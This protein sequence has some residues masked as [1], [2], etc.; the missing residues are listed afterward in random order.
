MIIWLIGLSGSGK[1]TLGRALHQKLKARHPNLIFVDGD[2]F[3]EM[4]GNDLGFT[5]GDRERNARR[6]SHFCRFL[7]LQGI[8]MICCVLSNF[9]EWQKWNRENF[10]QY[11]EIFLDTP[12]K[13][14]ARR[15]KKNLYKP[16]LAGEKSNV[17]GVDIPFIP[18]S[19][20]DLRL[21]TDQEQENS[22][23]LIDR[24]LQALPDFE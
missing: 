16:A 9:P 2:D 11:F 24:V 15:D 18:P 19:H 8:H 6:F 10:G 21:E 3:R 4:M 20:P 5:P 7:D 1:T 17:V 13:T 22:D 14:L 12:L 23:F